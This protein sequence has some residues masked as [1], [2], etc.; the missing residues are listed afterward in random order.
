MHRPGGTGDRKPNT[1]QN[2]NGL[3]RKPP[4]GTENRKPNT[5][6]NRHGLA[7]KPANRTGTRKP[8][9]NQNRNGHTRE[10]DS[11]GLD[12]KVFVP[13]GSRGYHSFAGTSY[14]YTSDMSD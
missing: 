12:P 9:T 10:N 7:R 4:N 5:N 8:N 13:I 1:K 6:Q 14:A 11:N 2:R 3:A